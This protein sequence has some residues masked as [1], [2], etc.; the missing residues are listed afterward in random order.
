MENFKVLI[1]VKNRLDELK[2]ICR[3]VETLPTTVCF[4]KRN[5]CEIQ[6]ILEEIFTNIVNH[7]FT[8]EKE[9]IEHEIEIKLTCRNDT[10]T[11]VFEDDGNSFDPTEMS[12][13]DVKCAVEQRL[14]GGLGIHFV[15]HFIDTCSYKREKGKNIMILEKKLIK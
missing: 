12:S 13:P 14:I 8:D 1:R 2:T 6:L 10:L 11:I 3:A 5:S 15:K 9:K 7:G 4:S